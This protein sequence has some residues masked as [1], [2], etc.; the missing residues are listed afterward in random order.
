[1][2]DDDGICTGNIS[3]YN[4]SRTTPI[5]QTTQNNNG[6]YI[7]VFAADALG[8][9]Y[10]LSSSIA[11]SV[12]PVPATPSGGGGGGGSYFFIPDDCGKTSRLPGSNKDGIDYSPSYYDKTCIGDGVAVITDA[13]EK[14]ISEKIQEYSHASSP[15][16]TI[17]NHS[18]GQELEDAYSFACT[19]GITTME[20]ISDANLKG[21]LIRSHMAKMMTVFAIKHLDKVPDIS[22]TAC[23][24]YDDI[25]TQS[26]E[27]QKYMIWACQLGLMGLESN[28]VTPLE[29]FN[30]NDI[31]DRAQFGTIL[32]RLI[33]GSKNN[34]E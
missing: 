5:S 34:T 26:S 19:D 10:F 4:Y 22:N 33:R 29:S 27:L 23:E 12:Q 11:I 6:Q 20:N 2:F 9:T 24:T 17:D 32:S 8:N 30:P 18:Y 28:G 14:T 13:T 1:M 15:T 16:C 21:E 3:A 25:D 7:C 31:V